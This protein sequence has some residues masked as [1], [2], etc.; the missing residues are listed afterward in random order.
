VATT[1]PRNRI[2]HPIPAHATA[3]EV[4]LQ[5]SGFRSVVYKEP[6]PASAESRPLGRCGHSR[7]DRGLCQRRS[8]RRGQG[9]RGAESSEA[10]R[11]TECLTLYG[12]V[13]RAT[14]GEWRRAFATPACGR[15]ERIVLGCDAIAT[16]RV[17][18]RLVCSWGIDDRRTHCE[19]W[20]KATE[21]RS[22]RR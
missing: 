22:R 11:H 14:Q 7:R 20:Y 19:C 5:Y 18:F 4:T 21:L 1:K 12:S 13:K 9:W 8:E 17:V 15:A 2:P 10:E 3:H 16:S 6:T